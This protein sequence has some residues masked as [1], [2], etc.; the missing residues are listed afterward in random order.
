MLGQ[1]SMVLG[2]RVSNLRLISG[3]RY[4]LQHSQVKF[5]NPASF[6]IVFPR[7]GVSPPANGRKSC[8]IRQRG[9]PCPTCAHGS[10]GRGP[11]MFRLV[12]LSK[13]ECD[14]GSS[15][16]LAYGQISEIDRTPGKTY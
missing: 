6:F 12:V 5:T 7:V 15:I 14:S 10:H 13:S 11:K 4:Q 2:D 9:A 3:I 1:R 16:N 8:E